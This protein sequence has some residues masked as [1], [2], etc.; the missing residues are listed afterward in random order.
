VG[1]GYCLTLETVN[2]GIACDIGEETYTCHFTGA[3]VLRARG[4]IPSTATTTATWNEL[5]VCPG[6]GLCDQPVWELDLACSW[7]T[8]GGCEVSKDL[9]EWSVTGENRGGCFYADGVVDDLATLGPVG[10]PGPVNVHIFE[11]TDPI[12]TCADE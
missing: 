5:I 10:A 12:D 2:L 9:S 8:E 1:E 7:L 4:P 3:I 11:V 6:P